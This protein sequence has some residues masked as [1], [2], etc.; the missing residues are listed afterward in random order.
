MYKKLSL[1]TLNLCFISIFG[2]PPDEHKN[3]TLEKSHLNRKILKL[4]QHFISNNNILVRSIEHTSH[5]IFNIH[6]TYVKQ[7][8]IGRL[9]F[10]I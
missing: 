10:F 3:K 2:I 7:T 5:I 1:L 8:C 9:H 6:H 4:M